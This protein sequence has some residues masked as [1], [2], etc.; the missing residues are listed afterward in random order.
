MANI[1]GCAALEKRLALYFDFVLFFFS[2]NKTWTFIFNLLCFKRFLWTFAWHIFPHSSLI[3]K[4]KGVQVHMALYLHFLEQTRYWGFRV[5]L[6]LIESHSARL[7]FLFLCKTRKKAWFASIYHVIKRIL[8]LV[9]IFLCFVRFT[10]KH[11]VYLLHCG[12][13]TL[14]KC[15]R[16]F[17]IFDKVV[18]F[19]LRFA[20]V[21]LTFHKLYNLI[22]GIVEP[23]EE[24]W[25]QLFKLRELF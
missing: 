10:C 2:L 8:W 4:R 21:S 13:C 1:T 11:F 22:A 7:E 20:V 18:P 17:M 24:L 6:P 25:V 12:F 19:D 14:H 23:L 15:H 5:E 9:H 3:T 16:F